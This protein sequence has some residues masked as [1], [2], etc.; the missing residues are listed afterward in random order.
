MSDEELLG[1][2]DTTMPRVVERPPSSL[3]VKLGVVKTPLQAIYV[4]CGVAVIGVMY[5]GHVILL[6]VPKA[7]VTPSEYAERASQSQANALQHLAP[8]K[9]TP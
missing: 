3:L 5:T 1:V 9:P 8:A 2:D 4:W 7:T 6:H